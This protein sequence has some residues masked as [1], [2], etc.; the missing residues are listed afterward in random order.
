MLLIMKYNVVLVLYNV[1]LVTL[2]LKSQRHKGKGQW[3]ATDPKP[4]LLTRRY[5]SW[6]DPRCHSSD[7]AH[8]C[9]MPGQGLVYLNLKKR[10]KLC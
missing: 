6:K 9:W 10:L 1:V 4:K 7:T 5:T 3:A 8:I 2:V